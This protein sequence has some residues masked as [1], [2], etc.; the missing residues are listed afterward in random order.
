MA[1]Y[2]FRTGRLLGNGSAVHR[3]F[4]CHLDVAS[5]TFASRACRPIGFLYKS[6]LAVNRGTAEQR[7]VPQS[8][9]V[10][11]PGCQNFPRS[12]VE[13]SLYGTERLDRSVLIAPPID[14]SRWCLPIGGIGKVFCSWRPLP[15]LRSRCYGRQ[16]Q[17]QRRLNISI[18]CRI[19]GL[20]MVAGRAVRP[21]GAKTPPMRFD[22]VA[23]MRAAR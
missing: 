2:P 10:L 16:C 11:N 6:C 7:L 22:L 9:N 20:R 8:A 5:R 3:C 4:S 1:L 14:I 23:S 18:D 15:P 13:K 19:S 17:R 21:E 12:G